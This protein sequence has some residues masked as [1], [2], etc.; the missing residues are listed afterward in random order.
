MDQD[1]QGNRETSSAHRGKPRRVGPRTRSRSNGM[2]A[3]LA[4]L[5][6]LVSR[7]LIIAVLVAVVLGRWGRAPAQPVSSTPRQAAP[8]GLR[9][10]DPFLFA[11]PRRAR[12]LLDAETGATRLLDL[13]DATAVDAVSVS[14]WLDADGRRVLTGRWLV[15]TGDAS[16]R[17]PGI[18][19][20]ARWTY[21]GG[22]II[23]RVAIEP[24]PF[25]P[26]CWFPDGSDRIL[27]AAGDGH[28]YHYDF[29][30]ARGNES[31]APRPIRWEAGPRG[32]ELPHVR[33]P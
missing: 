13:P 15:G 10:F 28:L 5:P 26:P 14:P 22:R 29:R 16:R 19:M 9:V 7:V 25:S 1:P 20:L 18:A 30:E 8:P 24:L 11:D 31:A 32:A 21:P 12:R 27:F 33:D 2:K 4:R 23:D 17:L 3:F 6:G